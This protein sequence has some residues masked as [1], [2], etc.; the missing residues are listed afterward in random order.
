MLPDITVLLALLFGLG[1]LG[2]PPAGDPLHS[3]G[4]VLLSVV[5]SAWLIASAGRRARLAVAQGDLPLAEAGRRWTTIW[6]L[7]GFMAAIWMFDWGGTVTALVPRIWWIAGP[8]LLFTPACLLFVLA[9]R[10]RATIEGAVLSAGGKPLPPHVTSPVRTAVRRNGML[11]LPILM[12]YAVL[13]ALWVA[14][15]LGVEPLQV[16]SAWMDV[17]PLASFGVATLVLL[18][19][20]PFI[21]WVMQRFLRA[22]SF[23]D[24][25]LRRSLEHASKRIGLRYRDIVLWRTNN[26]MANAMVVGFTGGT[27]RIFLTDALVNSLTHDETMAVFFHEAGHAKRWHLPLFLVI[28]L[29]LSLL[30]HGMESSF[31]MV[32]LPVELTMLMYLGVI[33]FIV[34]G[35]VSRRFE[36]EADLYGA[37]HASIL[38][39]DAPAVDVPG[40][41]RPIPRGAALMIRALDRVRQVSGRG[42]SHRH[43]TIDERMAYIAAHASTPS[44]REAWHR[45]RRNLLLGIAGLLCISVG[46]TVT[47]YHA[48]VAVARATMLSRAAGAD[49]DAAVRA[50]RAG[51]LAAAKPLWESAYAGFL[52]AGAH[53]EGEDEA[54]ARVLHAHVTWAAGDTA[55]HGLRDPERAKPHFEALLAALEKPLGGAMGT[56]EYRFQ[57]HIELGRIA[58]WLGAPRDEARKHLLAA[59][60]SRLLRAPRDELSE[61][62]L[63]RRDYF[64]ERRRLLDAT[65]EARISGPAG[66]KLAKQELISL[67]G[68]ANKSDEWREL[69]EDAALELERLEAL[70][71]GD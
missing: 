5:M 9:W 62:E 21:P 8:A 32:G 27:R 10:Q 52:K 60:M 38:D 28:M 45:N 6:A 44:V 14:G 41:P 49:Y 43:G 24:G 68:S 46:L 29:S 70:D 11:L 26:T 71:L 34:F 65:I 16:L 39:P 48:E 19:C 23:P 40:L 17:M 50:T 13:E 42:T 12:L 2:T 7:F 54:R 3:A 31:M 69:R 64:N 59:G 1:A 36:R 58:A 53:V 67:T 47:H 55:M 37:E 15:A 33:W 35:F 61:R 20:L 22:H 4:G 25:P 18:L 66:A 30:F 57:T 56:D 63:G 51:D